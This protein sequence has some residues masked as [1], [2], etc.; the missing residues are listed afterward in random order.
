MMCTKCRTRRLLVIIDGMDD[1]AIPELG[2]RTPAAYAAMP[3]LDFMRSHGRVSHRLTI[4]AGFEPSTDIALMTILDVPVGKNFNAR[5]WFEALGQGLAVGDDDLTLRCNLIT[6]RD[7]RIVSHCGFNPNSRESCEIFG[8]LDSYFGGNGFRFHSFGNFRGVLIVRNCTASI[9]A[10]PP[11][12]LLGQSTGRLKVVSDDPVLENCLNRCIVHARTILKDHTA[13]GIALWAPGHAVSLPRSIKG[14][15][16]AGVNVVKGIG[17]ALGMK[18]TDVPGATGDEH[19]DYSAKLTAALEA[20]ENDD[21]VLLHIEAAD[22]ASH[23]LDWRKKVEILEQIDSHVLAPLLTCRE[24]FHVT[25]M[26]DHATSSLTGKH[27][28]VPVEVVDFST[29]LS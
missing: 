3:G 11:H 14:T 15:V 9:E 7:G 24:E 5:S 12:M 28:A 25:V 27:L 29:K 23:Q 18:V 4:P 10:I 22:E 21:F 6:H 8:M 19:T 17:C 2:N 16:V 13:N 1:D 26:A 20:L